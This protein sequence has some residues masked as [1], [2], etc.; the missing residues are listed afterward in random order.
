MVP[1][2]LEHPAVDAVLSTAAALLDMEVVFVG[3]LTDAGL[4]VIGQRYTGSD[5]PGRR[6]NGPDFAS[7]RI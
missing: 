3:G 6:P 7:P 5:R 1:A 4:T 2:S